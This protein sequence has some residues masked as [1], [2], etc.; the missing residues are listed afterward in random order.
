MA[1]LL[2]EIESRV[3]SCDSPLVLVAIASALDIASEPL[4]VMWNDSARV[5]DGIM[6]RSHRKY[7]TISI[8]MIG[9]ILSDK[10][11]KVL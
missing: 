3:I 10:K 11:G 1:S 7:H 9:G 8:W 6:A 5:A 4:L 2:F